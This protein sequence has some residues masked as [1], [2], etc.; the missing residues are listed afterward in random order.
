MF[1]LSFCPRKDS[2]WLDQ[3][4]PALGERPYS[5]ESQMGQPAEL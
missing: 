3:P 2:V 1:K 4:P 5:R